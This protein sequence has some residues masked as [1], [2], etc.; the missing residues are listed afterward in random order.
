MGDGGVNERWGVHGEY[1][2]L[3]APNNEESDILLINY[4]KILYSF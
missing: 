2:H 1:G 3:P 4:F